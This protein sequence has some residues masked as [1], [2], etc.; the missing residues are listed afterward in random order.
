MKSPNYRP[1]LQ[2][3]A[4]TCKYKRIY[5]RTEGDETNQENFSEILFLD[6]MI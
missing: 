1:Y 5:R 6:V 2:C 4:T 3:G